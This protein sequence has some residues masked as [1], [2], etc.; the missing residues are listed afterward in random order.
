MPHVD[1]LRNLQRA[2]GAQLRAFRTLRGWTQE[3]LAG[4]ADL[5]PRHLQ[6]VEA[7]EVNVTLCTLW[8][9]A[10]ALGVDVTELFPGAPGRDRLAVNAA[11]DAD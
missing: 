8:R 11:A 9:L 2:L 3:A 7:G 4:R 5:A 6:K 1:G 10:S